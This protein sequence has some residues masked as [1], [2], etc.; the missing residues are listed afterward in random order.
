MFTASE[1]VKEFQEMYKWHVPYTWEG[2]DYS[3]QNGEVTGSLGCAGAFVCAYRRHGLSIYNGSNRIQRVYCEPM[4]SVSEAKAKGL[5]EP[6]MAVFKK[7]APGDAGYKLPDCYKK[8]GSHYNGDLNDYY[9]IGLLDTDTR[10]VL[11]A[12]ST[13]TGFVRSP[14]SQNWCGVARLKAVTYPGESKGDEK[15]GETLYVYAENGLPVKLRMGPAVNQPIRQELKC[16]TK[17][18]KIGEANADWFRVTT[19]AVTGYMMS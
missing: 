5:L 14:I 8:G 18:T 12:Q 13:Q 6:G 2:T 4:M 1:I 16:G 15:M 10:Y 9:H 19:G 3:V 17:V 11:N 7:R